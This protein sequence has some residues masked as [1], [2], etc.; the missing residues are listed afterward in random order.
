[1]LSERRLQRRSSALFE[2]SLRKIDCEMVSGNKSGDSKYKFILGFRDM[3]QHKLKGKALGH[4]S[5]KTMQL[6]KA[7][8][9]V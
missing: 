7:H 4:L 2:V 1:M 5:I 6:L 8:M 3:W 9:Q